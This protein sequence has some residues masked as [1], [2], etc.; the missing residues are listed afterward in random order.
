VK[1][2]KALASEELLHRQVNP[3]F[4]KDGRVTSAAF[5]PTKKD[6]GLL[7]VNRGSMCSAEEAH[8]AFVAR[9][10]S[11]WGTLTIAVSEVT[12]VQLTALEAPLNVAD[13]PEEQFDD[14]THA[15]VDFRS[16]NDNKKQIEKRA[17]ILRDNAVRR[18]AYEAKEGPRVQ[19]PAGTSTP[20]YGVGAAIAQVPVARA[21]ESAVETTDSTTPND[22][23]QGIAKA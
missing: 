21:A 1:V 2:G 9:G 7:S 11:S 16:L 23:A 10:W 19:T 6:K 12:A 8:R 20:A 3:N 15:V 18:G 5:Q 13:D 14:E 4:M 17:R 22:P